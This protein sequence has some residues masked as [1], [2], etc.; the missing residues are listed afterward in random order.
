[1]FIFKVGDVAPVTM[2]YYNDFDPE[3]AIFTPR[4]DSP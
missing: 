2:F 1:M 3:P 4:Q